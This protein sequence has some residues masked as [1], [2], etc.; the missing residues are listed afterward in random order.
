MWAI[1]ATHVV[2][3]GALAMLTKQVYRPDQTMFGFFV[4]AFGSQ[5]QLPA[6]ALHVTLH[7]LLDPRNGLPQG[8]I[9]LVN[10]VCFCIFL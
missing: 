4:G 10:T 7:Y 6:V 8:F 9:A 5:L 2:A 1:A 3:L